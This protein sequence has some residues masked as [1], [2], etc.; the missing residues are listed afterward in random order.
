[1]YSRAD[2]SRTRAIVVALFFT[3]ISTSTLAREFRTADTQSKDCPAV[4][5]P[6]YMGRLIA[7]RSGGCHQMIVR[8]RKVE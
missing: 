7:E 2:L 3:A 5:A 8:I 4:Q 1:V 6:S